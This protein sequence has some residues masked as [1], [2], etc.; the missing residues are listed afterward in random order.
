MEHRKGLFRRTNQAPTKTLDKPARMDEAT[1]KSAIK[2][3]MKKGVRNNMEE[4][5]RTWSIGT[6]NIRSIA[7]KERELKDKFRKAN[8]EVLAI[9]ETKKKGQGAEKMENGHLLIHTGVSEKV[10]AAAGV[11]CILHRSVVEHL[12]EWKASTSPVKMPALPK[13]KE[14]KY[15]N[16]LQGIVFAFIQVCPNMVKKPPEQKKQE[17]SL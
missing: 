12:I 17:V 1:T 2:M 7:G 10:R 15:M 9:T 14:A 4:I 5:N 16:V 11:A 3:D 13:S 8:M 6:W